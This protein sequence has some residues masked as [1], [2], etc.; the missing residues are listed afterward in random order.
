MFSKHRQ[1]QYFMWLAVLFIVTGYHT[2]GTATFMTQNV[3][4]SYAIVWF[5][6]AG[7]TLDTRVYY[8]SLFSVYV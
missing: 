4:M 6:S 1:T 3:G 2:V 8:Y 5:C 7:N